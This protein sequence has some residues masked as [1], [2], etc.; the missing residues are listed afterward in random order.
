[1]LVNCYMNRLSYILQ[2]LDNLKMIDLTLLYNSCLSTTVV[3]LSFLVEGLFKL[4]LHVI[5]FMKW[6]A[7]IGKGPSAVNGRVRWEF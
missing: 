5:V 4:L 3:G 6:L 7:Y 2:R 1:M